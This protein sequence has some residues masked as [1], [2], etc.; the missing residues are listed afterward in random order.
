MDSKME[1][2]FCPWKANEM[3]GIRM[4]GVAFQLFEPSGFDQHPYRSNRLTTD[5][6]LRTR[7][8]VKSWIR[9]NLSRLERP[10]RPLEHHE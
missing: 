6:A 9:R 7:T 8:A 2:A 1:L 3:T 10:F 5:I 4:T